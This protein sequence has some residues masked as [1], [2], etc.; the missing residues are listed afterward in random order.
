MPTG[1]LTFPDIAGQWLCV[2]SARMK[3]ISL[4]NKILENTTNSRISYLIQ[5][6]LEKYKQYIKMVTKTNSI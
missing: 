6:K 1:H 3:W 4:F 2:E 5:F